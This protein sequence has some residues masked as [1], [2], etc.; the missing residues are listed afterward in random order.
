MHSF[1]GTRGLK[2]TNRQGSQL[3]LSAELQVPERIRAF[4]DATVGKK[5][6]PW[7]ERRNPLD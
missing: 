4:I 3:L 1:D 7:K 6:A 2:K 5:D